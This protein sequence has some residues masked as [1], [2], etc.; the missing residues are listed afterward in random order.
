MEEIDGRK[1]VQNIESHQ[2]IN[3]SSKNM[4]QNT[5]ALQHT[6]AHAHAHAHAH[7]H[8]RDLF[9]RQIPRKQKQIYR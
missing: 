8:T 3:N 7:T 5:T 2:R 4:V 6:H 1:K 9:E